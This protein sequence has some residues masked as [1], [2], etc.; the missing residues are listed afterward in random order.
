LQYLEKAA[1]AK[2]VLSPTVTIIPFFPRARTA[3]RDFLQ[4]PSV[5]NT[6]EFIA[7]FHETIP[8][9]ETTKAPQR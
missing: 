7:C 8:I 5:I 2:R 9:K 1:V 6:S 4:C 3:A